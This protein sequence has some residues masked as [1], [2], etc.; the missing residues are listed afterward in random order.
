MTHT[1]LKKEYLTFKL[2]NKVKKI[3]LKYNIIFYLDIL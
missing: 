2:A 1:H 3:N